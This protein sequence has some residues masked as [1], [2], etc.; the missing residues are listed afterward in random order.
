MGYENVKEFVELATKKAKE[1]LKELDAPGLTIE[2]IA[3]VFC[4]TFEWS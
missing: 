2:D 1:N 4:Y 3:T